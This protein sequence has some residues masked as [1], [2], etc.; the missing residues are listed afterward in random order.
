MPLEVLPLLV[1]LGAPVD[2]APL[3]CPACDPA[4]D[5][6]G[7]EV[8][9]IGRHVLHLDWA[10]LHP[11]HHLLL[12]PLE[13]Q[14]PLLGLVDGSSVGGRRGAGAG[15]RWREAVLPVGHGLERGG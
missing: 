3:T 15:G 9:L 4:V 8:I 7:V 14:S 10:L 6:V 1:G 11:V 2:V 5:D 12:V 13:C